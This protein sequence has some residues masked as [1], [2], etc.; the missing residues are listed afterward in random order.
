MPG[1][2]LL[3]FLLE[4]GALPEPATRRLTRQLIRALAAMHDMNVVH[5]DVKPEN[6]MVVDPEVPSKCK[7]VNPAQMPF[8]A[9]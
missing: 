7:L 3:N 8:I 6:L 4:R 2:E 9:I 5:R 1:V